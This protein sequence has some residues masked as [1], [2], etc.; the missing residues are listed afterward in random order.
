[1]SDSVE[2]L[3]KEGWRLKTSDER[4][5]KCS[6]CGLEPTAYYMLRYNK[7]Y[8]K[9]CLFDVKINVFEALHIIDIIVLNRQE[10]KSNGTNKEPIRRR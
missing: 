10:N 6:I 9:E 3:E 2:Y 4:N 7:T 5:K 1:M 8:C